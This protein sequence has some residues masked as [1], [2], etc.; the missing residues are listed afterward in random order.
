MFNLYCPPCFAAIGAI[1]REMNNPRWTAF[2]VSYQLVYGYALALMVYQ[3]GS[4][5]SGGGFNAGTAAGFAVLALL[6]YLLVRKPGEKK[7]SR[8]RTF[9]GAA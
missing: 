3:L 7:P 9:R 5:V 1:K 2:A 4:F 6:V 8:A